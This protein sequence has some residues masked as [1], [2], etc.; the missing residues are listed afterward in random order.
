GFQVGTNISVN[1]S[2]STP[3]YYWAAFARPTCG[4]VADATY[5]AA[6]AQSGSV[7]I[8]W[9]SSNPVLIL[10]KTTA[11]VASEAPANGAAYAVNDPIGS[12]G[13][14]VVF[15]GSGG[16]TSYTRG[17]TNGSTYYYKVFSQTA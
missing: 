10:R 15:S 6:N 7:I 14:T 11:F 2:T 3:L 1:S 4:S 12:G 13:A 9:S 5:A 16:E 17:E 8:N